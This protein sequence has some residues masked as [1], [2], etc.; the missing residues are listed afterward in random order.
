MKKIKLFV[1]AHVFD[2]PRQGSTT[3]V[4]GLYN[5][6]L[7]YE[8]LEIYFGAHNVDALS[9]SIPGAQN[10]IPYTKQ[11]FVARYITHVPEIIRKEGFDLAHFQYIVPLV[12][13]N[14]KYITTVHDVLFIDYPEYFSWFFRTS[15]RILF[16]HAFKHSLIKLTV[17]QYSQNRIAHHFNITT[18]DID[19]IPNAVPN[20]GDFSKKDSRKVVFSK[21]GLK[22]FILFVSRLESRKNHVLLIGAFKELGLDNLGYQLVFVGNEEPEQKQVAEKVKEAVNQNSSI[23]WFYDIDQK[24]LEQLFIAADIFVYPSVAEGFGIPP[25]E[26]ARVNTPVLCSNQTAMEDFD[27]FKQGLFN[28]LIPGELTRK[29]KEILIDKTISL[30][31]DVYQR[32]YDRYNWKR[33]AEL[34]HNLIVTKFYK[35]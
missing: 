12:N 33:S 26:A 5:E 28:P 2:I 35:P 27:F 29:L 31:T 25:L 24:D 32:I 23:L 34:L 21:F 13:C 16:H 20:V 6:L 17:S 11:G 4:T 10:I 3:Y 18:E 15:R 7:K 8:D 30:P 9:A 19:V 14:T 22:K 1:E